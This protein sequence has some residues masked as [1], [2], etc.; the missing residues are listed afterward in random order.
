[1]LIIYFFLKFYVSTEKNMSQIHSRDYIF[2]LQNGFG[3]FGMPPLPLSRE[4][5]EHLHPMAAAEFE[6]HMHP[7]QAAAE[8]D[9]ERKLEQIRRKHN[10]LEPNRK[11]GVAPLCGFEEGEEEDRERE[12]RRIMGAYVSGNFQVNGIVPLK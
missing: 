7:L 11:F 6:K 9:W 4:A 12:W 1:M 8:M 3:F 10:L 5:A 2:S